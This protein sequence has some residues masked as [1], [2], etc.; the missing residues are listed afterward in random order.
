MKI[1]A[2]LAKNPPAL[3][4][5]DTEYPLSPEQA[6]ELEKRIEAPQFQPSMQYTPPTEA[7]V[8]EYQLDQMTV[9]E[10]IEELQQ[11]PANTPVHIKTG[12]PNRTTEIESIYDGTETQ[13]YDGTVTAS[14]IVIA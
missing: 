11:Y 7:D 13:E 1:H 9:G 12:Y 8:P 5:G 4:I 10:V 14:K 6:A 3:L 2:L